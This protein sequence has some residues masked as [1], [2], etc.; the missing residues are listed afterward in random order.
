VEHAAHQEREVRAARNQ[1]LF[2]A[3]NEKLRSLNEALNSMTEE[4]VISCEC[5]DATCVQTLAIAGDDYMTV[6][7]NP[8]TFVVLPGHVYPDVENFVRETESYVVVEKISTAA[9]VVEQ[10]ASQEV[11]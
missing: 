5:A 10:L 8:R 11:Q 1:A 9:E 3:V 4:F 2:R 6:R 7:A